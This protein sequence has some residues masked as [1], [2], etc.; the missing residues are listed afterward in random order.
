MDGQDATPFAWFST[1]EMRRR[2]QSAR[3][4]MAAAGLD[5]LLISGE[6][7]F[8]Y[9]A[10]TSASLALHHSLTRPSIFILPLDREPIVVTQGAHNLAQTSLVNNVRGYQDLLT[11]PLREV[12]QA[13]RDAAPRLRT[14]GAELGQEQRMGMPVGA[15]LALTQSMSDV[16][17]IDAAPIF[18]RLRMVKSD[19]ELR[20]MRRAAEITARARQ[21]L[22]D[23]IHRDMTERDVVRTMRQLIHEEGGDRTAFVIMQH[24]LPG[25]RNQFPVDRPLIPG[26]LLAVDAGAYAA[27]YTIDYVRIAVLGEAS[28]LQRRVHQAV[29][30]VVETMRQALR[31]G[32]S[33]SQI[34]DVAVSAIHDSEFDPLAPERLT[35]S[36]QGHGQGI[37]PT[38]PPSICAAERT[39]LEPGMV[40]STEPGLR[41]GDIQVQWEDVHVITEN[42]SEPITLESAALRELSF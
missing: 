26:S 2:W 25:A 7:N 16:E 9:F 14:V 3:D 40:I 23:G 4:K 8:Q 20:Y 10:G 11:F 22:F 32:V 38:E 24:D 5:A 21:R 13:L 42:A 35:W 41:C 1:N 12:Q 33:C 15:Y 17:F 37:L 6:E 18:I 36:R 39:V 28:S 34:F 27:M 30:E 19:E 31:P 29:L